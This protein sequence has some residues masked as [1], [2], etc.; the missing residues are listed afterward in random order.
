[1]KINIINFED[2]YDII[3]NIEGDSMYSISIVFNNGE[4]MSYGYTS[5]DDFRNDYKHLVNE[6]H[7]IGG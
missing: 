2:V 7:N 1:M 4:C 6:F 5:K 3:P